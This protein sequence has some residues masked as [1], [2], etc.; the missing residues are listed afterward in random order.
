M[1]LVIVESPTKAKTLSKI[2][3]KNYDVQASMGH[4]RDLPKSGL[5]VDVDKNFEPT[6]EVPQKAKKT[7]TALKKSYK[8]AD[9]VVLATDPDREGEA[10]AWHLQ[11]L[12]TPK[13]KK[14]QKPFERVVFHEL[15]KSSI[16]H[17][18][19]HPTKLN[20]DL[21]DAQ[22]AR[23][24]LDRLVGYKL[25]PLLW[26]TVR[27]GLSAGRVQSVAVRLVVEKERERDAFKAEE[28]WS[29]N[30]DFED[31]KKNQISAE[32]IKTE[33]T[34]E[35]QAKKIEDDLN[36]DSFVISE[37]KQTQ[38]H[39]K[40]SAPFK[41]ST[42]QQNA[43][44]FYGM[45][46]Q[47]TMRAAQGLFEKG[48]ITYHRTDSISLSKEFI[49]ITR[50]HVKKTFGA[51]YLPEKPPVFKTKS[52]NAQEAHEAI[53]PT[54]L[55]A[56]PSSLKTVDEKKIYTLIYKRTLESQMTEAIYDQTGVT[57]K[58]GKGYLFKANGS[59]ISFDGWL[60]VG[61]SLGLDASGDGLKLLPEV[62]EGENLDL[63]ELA[64]KQHFT[65]PPARYSDASMIKKLEELG[66]GRPSTYAPTLSTIKARG[67]VDKEGRYYFPNDV[68]YVVSDLLVEHFPH[69]VSYKFTAEL[70]DSLDDIADGKTE[71]QPMIKD[72]FEP[73]EK[74]LEGKEKVLNKHD[75]TNLGET[76]EK[77]PECSKKLIFKLGK[78]GK[79]ISCSNYPDCKYAAP[80]EEEIVK[81]EDGNEITDFGKC[82]ECEN[83]HFTLKKGRFGKFLACSNYP[84]CKT[85]QPFLEKIG[86]NCPTCNEG[87][88]VVKKAKGRTFYG[89]SRY[90]DCDFSSWKKPVVE[91]SEEA[92]EEKELE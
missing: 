82:T 11:T 28:Y 39:R 38:R 17:A 34:T 42:L 83:G 21:V 52:K 32:L 15:T 7:I 70:E 86:I 76:G 44:N 78:Y 63:Q 81:D 89:C 47:K 45:S 51:R 77:C 66:I 2:L 67:Y 18:F 26:K 5:G 55:S 75:I 24:V 22:Q 80:L 57:V 46:A 40:A 50:N 30:A 31:P 10:I 36:N 14:D 27:Y 25:S 54:D 72:F 73:F 65:Q 59:V 68:A 48:M 53:R 8:A 62:V 23:R 61:K 58:S 43:A 56:L 71:W 88:V 29:I 85:T 41:T 49:E 12:L 33:V 19:E 64:L 20:V 79:F 16:E 1:K 91:G 87:D 6:Y 74:S 3:D 37:I 60:A 90:P 84:N 4:I 69:I 35:S 13:T 92:I 9:S